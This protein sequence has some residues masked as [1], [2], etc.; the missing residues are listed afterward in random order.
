MEDVTVLAGAPTTIDVTMTAIAPQVLS[1]T[2]TG[3]TPT[4]ALSVQFEV[5][6]S[7][8]VTGVDTAPP[9]D[10]F[11]IDVPSSQTLPDAQIVSVTGSDDRY[12]V[13]LSTG[14]GEAEQE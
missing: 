1:V 7:E 10:D 8:A 4:N 12:L 9:F 3:Q 11:S 14:V 13:S 5:L 2:R 6:F